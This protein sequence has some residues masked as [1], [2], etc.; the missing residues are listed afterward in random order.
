MQDAR[1]QRRAVG[2]EPGQPAYRL[3]VVDDKEMNRQLL[4]RLLGPLGFELREATNG[5]EA[6][7]I[8]RAW[9]PHLIWMDMRMPVMDG[10]EAT[11][12]I[13]ATLQGHATA[14]VALTASA[15]EEDRKIIL[16]EG[17][18]DYIRKPF[19]D[20]E[21]FD[22]LEKHL[23]VRFVYE[24]AEDDRPQTLDYEPRAADA[25][26]AK[27]MAALSPSIVGDLRQAARLGAVDSLQASIAQIRALDSGLADLL[28]AWADGYEHDRILALIEER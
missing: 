10:Y 8:W 15:L 17:C 19:R 20:Q 13:K 21:L 23:G 16:S 28:A 9:A 11:R 7:D 1:P 2:L 25:D 27:R 22:A 14:I 26:A 5:Q 18:D 6:I 3:L 12:R 24:T 4:V